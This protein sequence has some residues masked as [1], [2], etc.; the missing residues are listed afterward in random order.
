V[1]ISKRQLAKKLS[2]EGV[3]VCHYLVETMKRGQVDIDG[4]MRLT[5]EQIRQG[6]PLGSTRI[7]KGMKQ[8]YQ[9]GILG[10]KKEKGK[11]TGYRLYMDKY[12]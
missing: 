9:A 10:I 3:I 6:T 8:L 1:A 2:R 7:N 12:F 4:Y 11:P 5:T